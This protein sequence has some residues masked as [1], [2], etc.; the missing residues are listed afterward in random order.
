MVPRP[1]AEPVTEREQDRTDPTAAGP[2]G[3]GPPGTDPYR[4]RAVSRPSATTCSS[5]RTSPRPASRGAPRPRSSWRC[6]PAA[7]LQRRRAR[8]RARLGRAG[9]RPTPGGHRRHPRPDD[10]AG[11]VRLRR[12]SSRPGDLTLETRFRG[13]L[14]D[15][16]RGF[17]RSTFVDAD[18]VEQV[19]ATT[20][21]EATDARRAFPCWDEPAHKAVFAVTLVVDAD[22]FA[23]SNAAEIER[24]PVEDLPGKDVVRFADTMRDVHLPGGVHRGPAGGHRA[25]STSTA[26]RCGSCT[27]GGRATSPPTRS[28]SGPSASATSPTTTASPTPATSSTWWRCPTSPSAPWRTWAASPSGRSCCSST[29]DHAPRPSC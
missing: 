4:C 1:Y 26:R 19:I 29:R 8:D 21:F 28:R 3:G 10:R 17:Y 11:D 6:R 23:V 7:H 2:D 14:N 16:L 5:S 18:G 12:A 22:L 24:T 9:R 25:R 13:I 20:Q 27:P 15:K